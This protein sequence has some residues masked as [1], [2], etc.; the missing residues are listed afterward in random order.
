M[1]EKCP[2]CKTFNLITWG[3][4]HLCVRCQTYYIPTHTQPQTPTILTKEQFQTKL[5][6]FKKH[7]Q[8][9]TERHKKEI[10]RLNKILECIENSI[11]TEKWKKKE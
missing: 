9:E 2:N 10:E 11:I 5:N 4:D 7:F 1:S 3:L 8:S 6:E